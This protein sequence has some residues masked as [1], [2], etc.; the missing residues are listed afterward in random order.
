MA[1]EVLYAPQAFSPGLIALSY[2]I[3]YV[4]SLSTVELLQRRTSRRGAYNWYVAFAG[5][6]DVDGV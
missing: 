4:G 2:I 3:S 1:L 6:L 5:G